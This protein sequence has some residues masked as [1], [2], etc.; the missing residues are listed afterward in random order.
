M[1]AVAVLS[2]YVVN[3]VEKRPYAITVQEIIKLVNAILRNAIK[4]DCANV[5]LQKLLPTIRTVVINM[6]WTEKTFKTNF[7]KL[8]FD[9]RN[10]HVLESYIKESPRKLK[11]YLRTRTIEQESITRILG[12]DKNDRDFEL[13]VEIGSKYYKMIMKSDFDLLKK[14]TTMKIGNID[15]PKNV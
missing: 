2:A 11:K 12:I 5:I 15:E 14:N 9:Q 8:R 7:V 13:I 4:I 1:V 10:I 6:E 3:T